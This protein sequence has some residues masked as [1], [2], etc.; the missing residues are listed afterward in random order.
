MNV[1][2]DYRASRETAF[3]LV[4][5]NFNV[6]RTPKLYN[7]YNA[8]CGH[9]DIML[10]KI[11]EN[12][13]VAEPGVQEYFKRHLHNVEIKQ[14]KSILS[15]QYPHDI[16]Y[17]VAR[18][19]NC[20]FLNEQYTDRN[21]LDYFYNNSVRIINIKQGYAKCSICTISD[22]A[23]ITSDKGIAKTAEKNGFDVLTV[24]DSKIKLPDFEHGF[25][26]GATG[27][28]D[29][30]TLAVNGDIKRH[31]DFKRIIDFC[32]RYGVEVIS[33]NSGEI[34]DIGSIIVFR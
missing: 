18:I 32:G 6:V 20:A 10:H 29:K 31:D 30:N 34:T 23:I 8:I 27:L 5:M 13:A 7:V 2:I 1:I 14:G 26:G 3:A 9:P 15:G 24:D 22:K 19:G 28:L 17:N 25:I 12:L 4:K 16:A 11:S 21:I 33:L